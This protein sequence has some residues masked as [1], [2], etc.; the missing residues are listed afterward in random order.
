MLKSNKRRTAADSVN[1]HAHNKLDFAAKPHGNSWIDLVR[2][3]KERCPK[4]S[5]IYCKTALS[6]IGINVHSYMSAVC[7]ILGSVR[8]HMV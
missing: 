6:S 1:A 5:P 7:L 8:C 2:K 4:T 3:V